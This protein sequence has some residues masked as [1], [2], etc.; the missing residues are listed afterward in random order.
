MDPITF[1]DPAPDLVT[2]FWTLL[3]SDPDTGRDPVFHYDL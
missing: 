2:I 3:T 1:D